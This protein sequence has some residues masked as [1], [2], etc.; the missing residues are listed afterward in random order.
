MFKVEVF[1]IQDGAEET[2]VFQMASTRQGVGLMTL[3]V[4]RRTAQTMQFL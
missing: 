4:N 2:H 1:I 3:G